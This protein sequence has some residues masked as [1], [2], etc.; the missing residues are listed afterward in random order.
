VLQGVYDAVGLKK[1]AKS[2]DLPTFIDG[3]TE[4]RVYVDGKRVWGWVVP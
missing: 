1:K 4:K 2:T 3:A